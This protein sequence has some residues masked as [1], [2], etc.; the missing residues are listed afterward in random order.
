MN[1][2]NIPVITDRE[3]LYDKCENME[4][5][6]DK[7]Y[8]PLLDKHFSKTYKL[9]QENKQLEEDKNKLE[10]III[11]LSEKNDK[12]L[13]HYLIDNK[14]EQ[15]KLRS[16]KQLKREN[17]LLLNKSKAQII[18]ILLNTEERIDK[19]IEYLEG[20]DI[21]K[22]HECMEHNLVEVLEV[23]LEILKGS[24]NNE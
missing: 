13:N 16:V 1:E 10:K 12:L 11:E 17:Y 7:Y 2:E 6:F 5:L 24:D 23:L 14:I 19:A 4:Q 18:N 9:Q 8:L 21:Q 3:E 20:F 15:I 22:L